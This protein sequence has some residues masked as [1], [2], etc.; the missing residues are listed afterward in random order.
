M[1]IK[2]VFDTSSLK[3]GFFYLVNRKTEEVIREYG[4]RDVEW[5][6]PETVIEERR[7]QVLDDVRQLTKPVSR[8]A[9]LLGLD[10][11]VEEAD[12]PQ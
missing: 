7:R 6:L 2:V 4:N 12:W 3:A 8:F 9:R 5:L 10:L 1:I 11:P